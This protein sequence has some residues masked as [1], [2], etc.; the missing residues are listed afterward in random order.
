MIEIKDPKDCCGCTA[1][2]SICAHN[3]ITM[4]PDVLGFLYP[5]VDP[6]KCANCGLCEEVCQFNDNYDRSLNLPQPIAYAA[7]HKDFNEIM[8]SRSGAAFIAIS[9]YIIEQGG[10]IYGAGYK[11]HFCVVHKRATTKEERDEFRG[12]K[13]VQSD[14]TGVFQQV[15]KDLKN[16]LKVIF[17]GTPCQTSGLNGYVGKR[18]RENLYLIDIVC[19]GVPGPYIWRD[20]LAYLEKKHGSK[21]VYV[22]FRD[23][24]KFGWKAHK[25]TYKFE[26]ADNKVVNSIFT[27]MFYQHI[28]FRHSCGVCHFTNLHRPSDITIADYWGWQRTDPNFNIDDKGCSLILCNTE[29]GRLLFEAVKDKMHIIPAELVNVMQGKLSKPSSIHSKRIMME[30]DYR[31]KIQA[32]EKAYNTKLDYT[33]RYDDIAGLKNR[34][35]IQ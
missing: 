14:L 5:K 1:C 22:N 16:G 29:K 34:N 25:E 31:Q 7:R 26:G 12:S 8:R 11:D 9:D 10:V 15:K 21:I 35:L 28:I 24:E 19:H 32:Y 4:Q 30:K 18:L 13:Y 27:Y 17:S 6:S 20:Y 33:F 23:K 3:A 2:A